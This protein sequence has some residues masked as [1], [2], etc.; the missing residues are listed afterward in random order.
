VKVT[1]EIACPLF[2]NGGRGT[3]TS[4]FSSGTAVVAC[5]DQCNGGTFT[6]PVTR[7]ADYLDDAPTV[8]TYQHA[9]GLVTLTGCAA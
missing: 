8:T 5:C 3:V 9:N 4:S 1:T 6:V 2:C 7:V